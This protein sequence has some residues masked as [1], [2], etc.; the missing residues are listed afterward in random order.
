MVNLF[1]AVKRG[2]K[3]AFV[4]YIDLIK[5]IV[6]V[7]IL[8]TFL[9]NIGIIEYLAG[10]FSPMM[11]LFGLPGEAV[12]VLMTGYF[13]NLY[14]AIGAISSLQL[15]IREITILGAMLGLAHSLIIEGAVMKKMRVNV[16]KLVILR[17]GTSLVVGVI[18]NLIL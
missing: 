8:V 16:L 13:L 5:I 6:P 1:N 9:K 4:T 12:V 18:L 11:Q 2:C 7:Y 15:G 14:A 17:V 10:F 3:K